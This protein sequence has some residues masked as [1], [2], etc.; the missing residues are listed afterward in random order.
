MQL[1]NFVSSYLQ[2]FH[3]SLWK[4]FSY[5]YINLLKQASKSLLLLYEDFGVLIQIKHL[6]STVHTVDLSRI[7]KIH[8][9]Y[10]T[11]NYNIQ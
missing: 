10:S 8:F 9:L 5:N 6:K 2:T 3:T 4:C 7:N 11:Y 1:K